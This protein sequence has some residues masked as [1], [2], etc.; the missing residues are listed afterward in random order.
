MGK[1]E[2]IIN[3]ISSGI[4][5]A[6]YE[7]ME[8]MEERRAF[9]FKAPFLGEGQSLIIGVQERKSGTLDFKFSWAIGQLTSDCCMELLK[10]NYGGISPPFYT[11]VF[12]LKDNSGV[13][14]CLQSN[15]TVPSSTPPKEAVDIIDSD[16]MGILLFKIEWPEGV[17]VWSKDL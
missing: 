12:T 14:L 8:T 4:L 3:G 11:A 13:I 1:I 17:E 15:F 2:E 7:E 5:K 6:P 10:M 16:I 9:N